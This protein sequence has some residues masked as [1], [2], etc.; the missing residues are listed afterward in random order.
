V[1]MELVHT[2]S[3]VDV[4]NKEI[5]SEEHLKQVA[6]RQS[7]RLKNEIEKLEQRVADQQDRLNNIQNMIFKANE[8]MDQFKLEMNWNQEELEQWALAARQKEE[9]NLTLEKYRR[10]DEAKIKELTLN[11]EKLTIEVARKSKE[12]EQEVTETQ[13]AQ[14]ELDKTAE[15][16][17]R[18][19]AERHQL[20]LQWQDTVENSRKRDELINQTGEQYGSSKDFLD[21]KR[22]DLEDHKKKL[23]R[24][25]ENNKELE[26]NIAGE[27]RQLT[28]IRE[29]LA[30]FEEERNNLEGEV[31]ILR[32]QLSAFATELSNKRINVANMNQVLGE[33]M[34]RLDAA[35]K[36]YQATKERLTSEKNAQ[37]YLERANKVSEN[38][39][40]ESSN[41]LEE[42]DKEIRLQKETLFKES[43]K[44][45]KL[46]AEQAN[47]IGDISGTLSASRNL[48]ANIIKL[49]QEQQRQQEL[50]YNAEFQI[51]QMERKVSRASGE[52]SQEETKR[53][54]QEILEVQE[55]LDKKK[56]ALQKLTISNK[57]LEDERRNIERTINKIKDQRFT[58]TSQI[59]E[60]KLENEMANG[61]LEKVLKNKEKTLVQHDCMKL[62]IKKLRDTV[63]VEADRVYGLENRKYQLEMSMEEREK[64]I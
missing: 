14:I 9:D 3:L 1:Q 25:K 48:Q 43:Q 39:Y 17:K 29:S 37:D 58:L 22:S 49:K 24:E 7:G 61:D 26:S 56:E 15:E 32:N 46:R 28:K 16:F 10:A 13:A 51:Q 27:E 62:E 52:R 57:Q 12:L 4:K 54:Q 50:L 6:E 20:Y 34:Q 38:D 30:K 33:K 64:E 47:L 35:K 42:V 45:F 63:N 36:K 19:H 18:M 31:A 8:K 11:I 59:Q 23:E 2:Q 44:L 5:E 40:K 55:E 53:L 60:L 21:K 41:M